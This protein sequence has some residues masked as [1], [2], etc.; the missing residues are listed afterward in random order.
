MGVE[1]SLAE[2]GQGDGAGGGD[3]PCLLEAVGRLDGM[4]RAVGFRKGRKAASGRSRHIKTEEVED[5][6]G[7]EPRLAVFFNDVANREATE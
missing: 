7:D 2:L 6:S 3:H 1:C 5:I 4:Q